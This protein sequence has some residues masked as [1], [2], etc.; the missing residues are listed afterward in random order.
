MKPDRSLGGWG[1]CPSSALA[2][3]QCV[4]I[5]LGQ[6]GAGSSHNEDELTGGKHLTV[7]AAGWRGILRY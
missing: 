1:S 4:E 6:A 2:W 7:G 5:D 3:I